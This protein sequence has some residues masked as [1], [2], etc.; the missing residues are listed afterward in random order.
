MYSSSDQL[1][2]QQR[3]SQHRVCFKDPCPP[4]W[5]PNHNFLFQSGG[6]RTACADKNTHCGVI[7][8]EAAP[9]GSYFSA[10]ESVCAHFS[11]RLP[12]PLPGCRCRLGPGCLFGSLAQSS[13]R[14]LEKRPPHPC[15]QL[16]LSHSSFVHLSHRIHL[17]SRRPSLLV[18]LVFQH[19]F[20]KVMLNIKNIQHYFWEALMSF[21]FTQP[22]QPFVLCKKRKLFLCPYDTA[23]V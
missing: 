22:V 11:R 10:R 15:A 8:L 14:C 4:K 1:S 9:R 3:F 6:V 16:S 2:E 18:H 5:P 19:Y 23:S 17:P 7:S 21:T 20:P 13:S 12:W